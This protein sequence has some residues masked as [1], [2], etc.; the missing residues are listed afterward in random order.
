MTNRKFIIAKFLKTLGVQKKNKRLQDAASELQLL[1]EAEEILGRRIWQKTES[2][3]NYKGYYWS[4]KKLLEQRNEFLEKLQLIQN[5]LGEIKEHK[6]TRF[7]ETNK[8][9]SALEEANHKQR[10]KVEELRIQQDDIA[11]T[12][13][14]I[15]KLYDG[16][17]IK[18]QS[19]KS[20]SAPQESITKEE[21]NLLKLRERFDALKQKKK[22]CDLEYAR[23]RTLLEKVQHTISSRKRN[24]K[25]DASTNYEIIAKANKAISAY[26]SKIG[27][28][29]NELIENYQ[30]I[31]R[32]ISKEYF[33]DPDCKAAVKEKSQLIKIMDALRKSIDYNHTL[34]DR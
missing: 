23:Q 27:M 28:V 7:Q 12:A 22:N 13:K 3:E 14:N 15:R 34:A 2:L 17:V 29:D 33:L 16:T 6:Q 19:L 32:N 10:K 20:E 25:E 8:P 26:R 24:Y 4:I 21:E 11:K 18:L 30:D 31:G 9:A 5:K 1:R